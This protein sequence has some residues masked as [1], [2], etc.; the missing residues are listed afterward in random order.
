[1]FDLPQN[2][3]LRAITFFFCEII[4]PPRRRVEHDPLPLE[5]GPEIEQGQNH[6]SN[7]RR[8]RRDDVF[9]EIGSVAP[10]GVLEGV[11]IG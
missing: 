9:G 3:D 6:L 10:G 1:V 8:L 11:L 5:G 7:S 2:L 4:K